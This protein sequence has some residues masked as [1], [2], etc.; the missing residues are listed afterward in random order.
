MALAYK[1]RKGYM[2][3]DI[4]YTDD[5]LVGNRGWRLLGRNSFWRT[6]INFFP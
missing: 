4:N 3:E 5:Q 6:I 1:S 2:V